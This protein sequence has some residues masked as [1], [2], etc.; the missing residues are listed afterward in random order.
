MTARLLLSTT[1][2]E[3]LRQRALLPPLVL[4]P[5]FSLAPTG[6]GSTDE[7]L[8][9][10][11]RLGVALP[12][13]DG[14]TVHPSVASDLQVLGAPEVA[15]T[16]RAT[17]PGLDVHAC[18]ALSGPRGAGL[19][20]TGDTAVELSAFRATDLA[21]ELSRVVPAAAGDRQAPPVEEVPLD[22][23]LDGS[24]SR[25]QGRTTGTLLATVLAGPRAGRA[26]GVVGTVQWVWDGSG[27][28][29]LE[30]LPSRGGRPW[31]RLAP[32]EPADLGG[33][34]ASLVARAAA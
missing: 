6:E 21:A 14:W 29:G 10:L 24:G 31:V 13:D 30:A 25:L 18:L 28:T 2:L 20:R 16:V 9:L 19:L 1:A 7:A 26:A 32:V 17:R 12:T 22:V 15:V 34:V 27:W 23:L 11:Q 3:L 8:A 5:G 33:W 4:P